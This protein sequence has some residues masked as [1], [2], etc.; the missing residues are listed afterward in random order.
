[1]FFW[2]L[3]DDS[4]KKTIFLGQDYGQ[5]DNALKECFGDF[6]GYLL[7]NYEVVLTGLVTQYP[8][9][10]LSMK[11]DVQCQR[12]EPQRPTQPTASPQ[13]KEVEIVGIVGVPGT[14]HGSISST[15][16]GEGLGFEMV[17][18]I[19][20]RIMAM[21]PLGSRCK[22]KA[23]VDTDVGLVQQI[24]SIERLSPSP[25]PT[26]QAQPVP[27]TPSPKKEG[28]ASS[29][30]RISQEPET[31]K[32]KQAGAASRHEITLTT[33]TK[34][35]TLS[36]SLWVLTGQ[37]GEIL[38]FDARTETGKK[39][40]AVC[41]SQRYT[42]T[43][44][45]LI[46]DNGVLQELLSLESN[47]P[48]L[49]ALEG[50]SQAAQQRSQPASVSLVKPSFDCAKATTPVEIAICSDSGLAQL[51]LAMVKIYNLARERTDKRQLLAEQKKW[52]EELNQQ[53]GSSP[54]INQCTREKYLTRIQQL[55]QRLAAGGAP[56]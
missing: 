49:A 35:V 43:I 42:C 26:V 41:G 33:G 23:K 12:I 54:T 55:G 32:A 6:D 44:K 40:F 30:N 10:T 51:D 37:S 17:P 11:T 47:S 15:D 9:R 25:Q 21:C 38:L 27:S 45:A 29:P 16:G 8:D 2:Y 28:A 52:I 3:L 19:G 22:V 18:E 36:G 46:D 39:L 7:S 24:L 4:S 53:C 34:K 13:Y 48:T 5:H 56:K 50:K 1:M 20:H 14:S 31:P